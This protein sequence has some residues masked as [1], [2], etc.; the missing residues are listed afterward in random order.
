MRK[1]LRETRVVTEKRIGDSGPSLSLH[2]T[3]IPVDPLAPPSAEA[4]LAAFVVRSAFPPIAVVH[5]IPTEVIQKG[6]R[7]RYPHTQGTYTRT[8]ISG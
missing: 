8:L 3:Y 6:R 1:E 2:L 4:D 5:Y 7:R